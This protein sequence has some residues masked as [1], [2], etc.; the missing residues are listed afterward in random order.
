MKYPSHSVPLTFLGWNTISDCCC[1]IQQTECGWGYLQPNGNTLFLCP[2]AHVQKITI[3]FCLEGMVV[4]GISNA[5]GW[6]TQMTLRTEGRLLH[7]WAKTQKQ[8]ASDSVRSKRLRLP[9][10]LSFISKSRLCSRQTQTTMHRRCKKGWKRAH[11]W[12]FLP[13][14]KFWALI[15]CSNYN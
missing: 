6:L 5:T 14:I 2:I 3:V 8:R 15:L 9:S 10:L 7:F 4:M 12:P 1:Y 13:T 11:A